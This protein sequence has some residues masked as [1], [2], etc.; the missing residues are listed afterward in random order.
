[1]ELQ[2]RLALLDDNGDGKIDVGDTAYGGLRVDP[3]KSLRTL[4][5]NFIGIAANNHI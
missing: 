3:L 5:L 4:N 2:D 1:M